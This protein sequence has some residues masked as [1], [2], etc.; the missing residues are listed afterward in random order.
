MQTA[1]YK[2]YFNFSDKVKLLYFE[3]NRPQMSKHCKKL[4][5]KNYGTFF[6][7]CF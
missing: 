3:K 2:L 5:K 6:F 7:E 4:I 1:H